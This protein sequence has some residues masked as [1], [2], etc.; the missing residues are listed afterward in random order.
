MSDGGARSDSGVGTGVGPLS[1]KAIV[2]A[3]LEVMDA[4]GVDALSMRKLAARFGVSAQALYWHF[5]NKDELCQ[6]VVDHVRESFRF[7]ENPGLPLVER[8]RAHMSAL[9]DHWSRHPT[10]VALGLRFFP[11]EAGQVREAG[12]DL[13]RRMGFEEDEALLHYRA[14]LWTVLGFSYVEQ[15]VARSVHHFPVDV[16]RGLYEVRLSNPAKEDRGLP[17]RV[18]LLDVNQLF[19]TVVDLFLRGLTAKRRSR[20]TT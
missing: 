3:A 1:R 17:A 2:L 18:T 9:R 20:K 6:A 13:L 8:L 15:G 16:D 14:L 12:I 4:E 5:S 7:D 11:P 19:D 10:A